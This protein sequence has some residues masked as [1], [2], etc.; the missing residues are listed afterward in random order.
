LGNE[1]LAEEAVKRIYTLIGQMD[2]PQHLRSVGVRED[3][4]P[5]LAQLALQNRAVQSNPKQITN[6]AQIEEILRAAW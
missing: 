2:L 1:V 3:E 5:N 6:A 4:I